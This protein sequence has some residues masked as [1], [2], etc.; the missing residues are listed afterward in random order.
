MKATRFLLLVL[1][2]NCALALSVSLSHEVKGVSLCCDEN[3]YEFDY[4]KKECVCNRK[5][6]FFPTKNN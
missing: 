1:M 4:S 5:N 2:L 6:N 3:K